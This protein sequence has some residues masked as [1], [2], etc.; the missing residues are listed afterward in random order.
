[1]KKMISCLTAL[2]LLTA[3][4]SAAVFAADTSAAE[5][6]EKQTEM[7]ET[8]VSK[9]N[10]MNVIIGLT[11]GSDSTLEEYYKADD[12]RFKTAKSVRTFI[13]DT[14]TG[15]LRD[16]LLEKCKTCLLEKEDGLYIKSS[17][18]F[19]FTFLTGNG[20]VITDTTETSFKAVSMKCDQ[21]NDY[22]RAVFTL[23]DGK[24]KISDY[25]FG[26][27]TVNNDVIDLEDAA[28]TRIM[29]FQSILQ[30]LSYGAPFDSGD[31]ITVGE[32]TYGKAEDNYQYLNL[33][34]FKKEIRDNCTGELRDTLLKQFEERFIEKDGVIY[35]VIGARG[36]YDFN[37]N[38]RVIVTNASSDGYTATTVDKSDKDGYGRI[39]LTADDGKWLIK[40]YEFLDSNDA[41]DCSLG[42]VNN[43]GYIDAVDASSV[44]EYYALVSAAQLSNFSAVQKLAADVNH[45]DFIDAVDA[46]KILSYYAYLSTAKDEIIPLEEYIKA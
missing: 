20:V 4:P 26:V 18:R 43:D 1:M 3:L 14:C 42:D 9:M 10:D 27:F 12:E 45:D 35:A 37:L 36:Y 16:E 11:A 13:S 34:Y 5:S 7:S 23:D 30:V 29:H 39:V 33:D 32:K 15:D 8:A 25:E 41:L 28:Y 2:T 22:G 19:S 31:T 21:M 40:S 17:G 38:K 44:L 6:A 24:W 46:S